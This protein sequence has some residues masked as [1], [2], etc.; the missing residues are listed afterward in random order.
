MNF[1]IVKQFSKS[2]NFAKI[3]KNFR[4]MNHYELLGVNNQF[5]AAEL[6][7][8]YSSLVKHYHPDKLTGRADIF[9]AIKAAYSNIKTKESTVSGSEGQSK[10]Y[11]RDEKDPSF[12]AEFAKV[13]MTRVRKSILLRKSR[14]DPSKMLIY[15]NRLQ[16]KMT[17]GQYER[18]KLLNMLHA[19]KDKVNWSRIVAK[20]ES[21]KNYDDRLNDELERLKFS[22]TVKRAEEAK[23]NE[24]NEK[25]ANEVSFVLTFV[26]QMMVLYS[27]I[28]LFV[29]YRKWKTKKEIRS[30]M[31]EMR[32]KE[33]ESSRDRAQFVKDI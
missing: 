20:E 18:Q 32:R 6:K 14:L 12:E 4:T 33:K 26:G 22:K 3:D 11:K 24:E 13:D 30:E 25:K 16:A 10:G 23:T 1:S 7:R 31:K 2:L 29:L 19:E 5:T 21:V 28:G 17:K 15:K 8:N 27:I 9:K